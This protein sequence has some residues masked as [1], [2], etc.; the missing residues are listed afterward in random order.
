MKNLNKYLLPLLF[1]AFLSNYNQ[2]CCRNCDDEPID[3]TEVA[4]DTIF[5]NNQ[6]LKYWFFGEGSYW[7]YENET[8]S[9][10]QID[11]ATVV[12]SKRYV[13]CQRGLCVE[14]CYMKIK[15][16]HRSL[17]N[18]E[19]DNGD[20]QHFKNSLSS[21]LGVRSSEGTELSFPVMIY[22]PIVPRDVFNDGNMVFYDSTYQFVHYFQDSL[23]IQKT[24]N[25]GIHPYARNTVEYSRNV[26]VLS[27]VLPNGSNWTLKSCSLIKP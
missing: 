9:G 24:T 19:S 10:L 16:T 1:L 14:N 13:L 2:S 26:G 18:F 11:T 3:T 21:G 20:I 27:Y 4:F 17:I 25:Y 6:F 12:Y 23:Y 15:H 22:F 5:V 7:I 8:D